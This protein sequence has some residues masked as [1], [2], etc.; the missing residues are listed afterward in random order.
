MK[1][2]INKTIAEYHALFGYPAGKFFAADLYQIREIA[3]QSWKH[4]YGEVLFSA[5]SAALEA[6][7]MIGYKAAKREAKKRRR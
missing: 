2:D 7:F 4:G 3:L 1:R 6:G 5:I